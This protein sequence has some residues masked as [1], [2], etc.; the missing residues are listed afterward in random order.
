MNKSYFNKPESKVGFFAYASITI[1]L[2]IYTWLYIVIMFVGESE[3][4]TWGAIV[5][6]GF[7]TMLPWIILSIIATKLKHKSFFM[8]VFGIIVSS[9]SIFSLW[10]YYAMTLSSHPAEAAAAWGFAAVLAILWVVTCSILILLALMTVIRKI[11][12]SR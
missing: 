11:L 5:G 3:K 7:Y 12:R 4:Q 8:A 1:G 6:V 2:L 10:L 9:M